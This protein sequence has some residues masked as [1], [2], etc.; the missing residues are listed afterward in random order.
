MYGSHLSKREDVIGAARNAALLAALAVIPLVFITVLEVFKNKPDRRAFIII[1]FAAVIFTAP[2]S[3][4][5]PFESAVEALQSKFTFSRAKS[6]PIIAVIAF[7]ADARIEGI[8][9]KWMEAVSIYINLRRR[10]SASGPGCGVL[11]KKRQ[12]NHAPLP[13][14][15]MWTTTII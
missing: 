6:V 12:A 1:F 5:N 8:V 13:S 7:A 4:S 2:A 11:E 3:L 15:N 9:G 14:M 10:R